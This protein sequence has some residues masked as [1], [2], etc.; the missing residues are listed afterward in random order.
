MRSGK[1]LTSAVELRRLRPLEW[2]RA[3][4]ERSVIVVWRSLSD[5]VSCLL[6]S[7]LVICVYAEAVYRIPRLTHAVI[8]SIWD[9]PI[10]ASSASANCE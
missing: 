2:V 5:C 8:P 1:M 3:A 9:D 6:C 10:F 4:F 7:V